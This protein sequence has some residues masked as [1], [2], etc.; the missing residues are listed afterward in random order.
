[1]RPTDLKSYT[2]ASTLPVK[3]LQNAFVVN[4]ICAGYIPPTHVQLNPT[5]RCN[6]KCDFCSC[7]ERD[8]KAEFDLERLL[9]VMVQ[10]KKLGCQAVTI[11]GG[12]EPL[13]YPDINILLKVLKEL[14]IQ[15]GL[16]TNGTQF[17]KLVNHKDI[18][19]CR[20]SSSDDREPYWEGI[21][22]AVKKGSNINWAF[23]HVLTST[24][25]WARLCRLVSF[26]NK[27]NF[28]HVRI[29]ADL[30]NIDLASS[31][32]KQARNH[33]Y[34][35]GVDDVKVIYQDR[36]E[37]VKGRKKCGISL[38]KPVI[39]ADGGV[40]PCCGVQYAQDPPGRDMVES[41]RMGTLDD[42]DRIWEEQIA[43]DGSICSRCYYD[44]Y[45]SALDLLTMPLIHKEFV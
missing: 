15:V 9:F 18:V 7:S 35:Q 1:M 36:A 43:F 22:N 42:I 44:D 41:M 32:V 39:S 10:F 21:E 8:K 37:Y 45:N 12:G 14:Q 25:D 16:V 33:L 5:N 23:S 13:L 26:A 28:T 31:Q 34:V 3:L 17:D 29:V 11:T 2:A 38:L 30:L 6:L 19:W 24:P 20:I 4:Q 27:N 40:Y